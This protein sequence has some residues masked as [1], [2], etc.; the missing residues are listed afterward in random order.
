M[1][2]APTKQGRTEIPIPSDVL[3]EFAKADLSRVAQQQLD[4]VVARIRRGK[5]ARVMIEGH[6]DSIGDDASNQRL[7]EQRAEAV[8]SYLARSA[9]GVAYEAHGFGETRPVA[10]NQ[11]ADGKDNPAGRQLNRRV[12]IILIT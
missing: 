9:G 10:P 2:L 6:T 4:G 1:D 11:T 12:T 3:F 5:P 8:R 7:S